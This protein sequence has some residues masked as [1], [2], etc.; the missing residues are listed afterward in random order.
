MPATDVARLR[1]V[2]ELE[3]QRGCDNQT[4]IGGLDRMLIQMSEEG[5]LARGNP[6]RERVRD[7][8]V[9]GYRSLGEPQRKVWIEGTIR[10]LTGRT[11][12]PEPIPFGAG[13]HRMERRSGQPAATSNGAVE[14]RAVRP[15]VPSP[16]PSARPGPISSPL[17]LE[18][19]SPVTKLP[20]ISKANAAR[21]E[22]LGVTTVGDAVRFFPRRFN[23]YTDMRKIAGLETSGL[24]QTVVG[25]IVKV[26]ELRFGRRIK[27]SEAVI[28]DGTGA[29]RIAWFNMPYVAKG[30]AIGETIVVSGK[31]RTFRGRLQMENP[32]YEQFDEELLHT[33]RLV[34]V[35]PATQ[36]L[37]QRT[38]RRAVKAALDQLAERIP[39]PV[40]GWLRD[41]EKLPPL[42][43]AIR[44]YHYPGSFGE[45]EDARRR[46]AIGEFLAIQTAVLMRRAEWQQGEDAP[47]LSL[48]RRLPAFLG[49]L[50]FS[51]T[52]AQ[53]EVMD[54]ILRDIRG[55]RPMLRLLQGDVGSG[56]TVVAF[57]A[58]LGAVHS[59]FQAAMM[60]PT[61]IL[62]EQHY[63]S[64]ATYLGGGDLT[65]LDGVFAPEWFGRSLRVLLLTGSLTPSQKLQV[66]SDAAHGGADI[67]IGTHA[68][69][70]D[71]VQV[72]RLGLAVIDE[73]HRF[74]VMQRAKLRQKG[75]NP[76][77]LVMTA[78]PI[79]RTLALTVY[80]DLEVSTIDEMPPGRKP[81]STV[82]VEPHERD[83]AYAFIRERLDAGEQ[84]FVICPLVE[85]SEALDVRSAEE[86][87]E[88]LR[89]GPL[90]AYRL[91][92][93]HGR[94]PGRQKDEI[95]ARLARRET[96]VL[97][98]TSVIE[99]GI[100][101]PGATV[102]V[103]EGAERFGLS[104]LHQFRGRV[105][106]S[107]K[108]SYC[109]LFS[110]EEDPGPD[111]R[112]RL[113]AMVE[114]TDGFKLAE[115]DLEMRGEGEAWGRVQS[116][117]NTMLRV[118]RLTD[119]DL[120]Y[121]ARSM[122]ETLLARDPLLQKPEHRSLAVS[123]KP[124]LERAAE[125]N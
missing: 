97:V 55:P 29:L 70:E 116:G 73:Q 46:L 122:A 109:M 66:R 52:R 9:G 24:P 8:P 36:G 64:L 69:L 1:R 98:S 35:Y 79:P 40:P 72:P 89:H 41:V 58:M 111:A 106:R 22:K 18:L 21:L 56:K 39:D 88:R 57:A 93:L 63:R 68:L 43:H 80:G 103:I 114:T 14:P 15:R 84:A 30:L 47:S 6:L 26:G 102:I 67:V 45:A 123:V 12:P 113:E 81:V 125:A 86:E 13:R 3:L 104:Q 48:G 75:P 96:D 11:G 92:L 54:E 85:E 110:T 105:G 20:G 25:K 5:L 78:T 87:F 101:V 95:M 4:V 50:P 119:R 44:T 100:D 32:E 16:A 121:R 65:A 124:F 117:A 28:S 112:E 62:A 115:V 10:S 59:G 90:R 107:E 33:G 49:S 118:A 53:T 91:D 83:E 74:G 82:W 77:L 38:I 61:E 51:L 76:H 71:D 23:D 7:L 37:G 60:A 120:L 94:M 108:Q 99:V 31:V 34:P 2:F 19:N 17:H 42:A 27:G